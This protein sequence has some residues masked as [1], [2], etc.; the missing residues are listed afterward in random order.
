MKIYTITYT[1]KNSELIEYFILKA[2]DAEDAI[3]ILK[4]AVKNVRVSEVRLGYF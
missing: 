1:T 4:R 2:K 3:K